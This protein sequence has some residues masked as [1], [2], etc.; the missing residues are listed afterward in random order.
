MVL[1]HSRFSVKTGLDEQKEAMGG[2]T[3]FIV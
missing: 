2:K 1:G 3:M